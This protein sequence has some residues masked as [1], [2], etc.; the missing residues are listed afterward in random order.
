MRPPD[1]GGGR[2]GIVLN[3]SPLFNGGAESG[4]CKIRRWLLEYDLV[5]AIVAL[6]TNM[7]YNTG[8]ATYIW[9]LDN[10]KRARAQGQGPAHRRHAFWT[11]MRKNLGAKG[12]EISDADREKSSSSTTPSRTRP[13]HS[14]VLANDEFG[15]WTITVERPLLD[16]DGNRS[17]TRKG[18]PEAG[19]EAARHRERAVHLRRLRRRC[20]GKIEVIQAYFDAE[21]L[22]HVPDAW[23]DWEEDQDGI[24]DPVHPALLQ[25]RPAPPLAEIDAD[26]E[27]QVAKI[28]DL[29]REVEG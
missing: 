9:I 13:D 17:S 10:T 29:L 25:V 7:F 27:K 12:R 14:K 23:I 21:V 3:G 5:D 22:P 24:R 15:Y 19:H 28:L 18:T 1:D 6:P 26:L 2:A 8:I 11:K 20:G 4:P 16:D